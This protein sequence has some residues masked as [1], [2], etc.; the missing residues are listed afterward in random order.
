MQNPSRSPFR[1]AIAVAAGSLLFVGHGRAG[2]NVWEGDVDANW[3]TPGNWSLGWVPVPADDVLFDATGN[4]PVTIDISFAVNTL[5]VTN[6]F[7]NAIVQRADGSTA[8][9]WRLFSGVWTYAGDVPAALTVGGDAVV[10]ARV[11][12]R[13]SSTAS[14]GAGR[15]FELGAT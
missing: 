2:L 10:D 13:R 1:L 3:S 5:T 4:T 12:C 6:G 9:D 14:N 7:T 11:E 15:V 8:A